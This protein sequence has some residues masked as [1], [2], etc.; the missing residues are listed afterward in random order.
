[1]EACTNL[2]VPVWTALTN[3]MLTNGLFHFSE[4]AQPASAGRFY[5]IGS[6]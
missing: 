4:P 6:P 1:V 2:G 3:V 5:R